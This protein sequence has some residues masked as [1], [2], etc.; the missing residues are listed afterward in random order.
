MNRTGRNIL[1]YLMTICMVFLCGYGVYGF[2]V[3]APKA[4]ADQEAIEE[5]LK[6]NQEMA[7]SRKQN[8]GKKPSAPAQIKPEDPCA[9][10]W[11]EAETASWKW[12][13][14]ATTMS[15]TIEGDS[16]ITAALPQLYERF[17]NAYIDARFGRTIFEGEQSLAQLEQQ[18]QIGDVLVIGLLTNVAEISVADC[19]KVYSHA[20][21]TPT[22]WLNT[23]GV[24]NNANAVFE[25]FRQGK[26]N[27]YMVDW[28]KLATEHP[29]YML[30]DWLHPN[31]EGSRALAD[32]IAET[33]NQELLIPYR[34]KNGF[35]GCTYE[36]PK[37]DQTGNFRF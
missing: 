35:K 18:H 22:F 21:D 1:Y 37:E 13:E 6:K 29:E 2:F 8:Q 12:Y 28:N 24:A 33:I 23:F 36:G 31:E 11:K 27:V 5:M 14:D 25:Q 19:E 26:D 20:G 9:K 30:S 16:V 3:E 34:E 17:P 32:L 15:L 4:H 7:E 10:L